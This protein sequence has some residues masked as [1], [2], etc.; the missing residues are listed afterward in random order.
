M[1]Y[2]V[3]PGAVDRG[4]VDNRVMMFACARQLEIEKAAGEDPNGL[5][6]NINQMEADESYAMR[7]LIANGMAMIADSIDLLTAAVITK[8][9]HDD[10]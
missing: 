5:D 4:E 10:E 6:L 7:L 9:T 3:D 8:G 1:A 2:E